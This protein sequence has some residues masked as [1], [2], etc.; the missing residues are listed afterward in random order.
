VPDDI[1]NLASTNG[2]KAVIQNRWRALS[3]KASKLDLGQ[4][5]RDYAPTRNNYD[6][7][8]AALKVFNGKRCS[9]PYRRKKWNP[10]RQHCEISVTTAE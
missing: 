4:H 7:I 10:R 1:F 3:P 5:R 6:E 8:V 9:P 2:H